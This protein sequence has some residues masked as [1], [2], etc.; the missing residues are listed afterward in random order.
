[1]SDFKTR[2]LI[3]N[4]SMGEYSYFTYNELNKKIILAEPAVKELCIYIDKYHIEYNTD[5][6]LV[7]TRYGIRVFSLNL[8][9]A[10]K[11]S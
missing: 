8:F 11:I 2:D 5:W 3:E 4:E 9:N 1:M 7:F 10:R 6:H